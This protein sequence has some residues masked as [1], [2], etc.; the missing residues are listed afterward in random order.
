MNREQAIFIELMMDL[1]FFGATEAIIFA[2]DDF[3]RNFDIK[4]LS[5][6]EV[7]QRAKECLLRY[8]SVLWEDEFLYEKRQ[9]VLE[10]LDL[11]DAVWEFLD[12]IDKSPSEQ[13]I[14]EECNQ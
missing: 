7:H 14:F 11:E 4:Q 2:F 1:D 5:D 13:N 9:D 12:E 8:Q 3:I 10:K 6:L